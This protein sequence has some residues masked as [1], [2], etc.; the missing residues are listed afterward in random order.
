MPDN[1]GLRFFALGVLIACSAI[2][3]G[4]EAAYFSLGR[5]RLRH[6]AD[7]SEAEGAPK[8]LIER[9]HELLVT[10]LIGITVINIGAAAIAATI[11]DSLFGPSWGVFVEMIVLI[12]VLTT[13]GEVLP[14][15]LAVKYPDRFLAFAGR[16]VA[17]L[18]VVLAP[19][20][21]ALAGLTALTVG[22]LG[23]GRVDQS[24]LSE[25]ELR[26]LVDVG[27]SE[28]VVE[29]A[30]REMIHK[31]FELEDTFVRSVMVPRTD[32]FCLDVA[33]PVGQILPALRE[34]LHSRV[35]VYERSIDVIVG[36]LYTK[37]LLSYVHGLPGNFDLRAHL[38]P[39]Y[40]VPETKRA[41]ALLKEFQAKKLHLAIVVDEYGGTAG[42]VSLEDLLEEVVGEIA[43]EYDEPER[44]VQRIDATT[45]RVAGKLPIDDL[46]EIT[47]LAV[48][49]QTYDTVG[50]WARDLCGRVPRQA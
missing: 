25:E 41:D 44:L 3:T 31:V 18:G 33:T 5:A 2:L 7:K 21:A 46:N 38:H 17:W 4:A 34:H 8:P 24:T 26:T 28:G 43:D 23:Q 10:L 16:P 32:M 37:D 50:G 42:L 6:V 40:F 14:M 35:P 13:F 1:L 45:Y 27:A 49:K 47:G 19:V 29:R 48:A 9:P 30:E 15:T 20:R 22:L 39:P 36:I 12:F 11:A